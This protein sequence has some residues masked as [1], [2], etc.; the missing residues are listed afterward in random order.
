[1]GRPQE[2][3]TYKCYKEARKAY[4]KT[5]RQA[6][7]K[8]THNRFGMINRL[9]K[10]DKAGRMWNIIRKTKNVT[11][12]TTALT[13]N[14]FEDYFREKFDAPKET[15]SVMEES[16]TKVQEKIRACSNV[17]Y[18]DYTITEYQVRK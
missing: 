3:Q 9:A 16:K 13:I 11:N 10:E 6:I 12:T 8:R 7:N 5:C 17:V 2:G 4:K 15:T 18:A 1:M 14:K